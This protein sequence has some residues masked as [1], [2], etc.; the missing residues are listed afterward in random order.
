MNNVIK[1]HWIIINN[2]INNYIKIQLLLPIVLAW[3]NTSF[4]QMHIQHV[5]M[6]PHQYRNF[7]YQFFRTMCSW[8]CRL[9]SVRCGEDNKFFQEICQSKTVAA[10]TCSWN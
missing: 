1:K 4:V 3:Q 7:F 6:I 5:I 2:F 9:W 10:D 8:V